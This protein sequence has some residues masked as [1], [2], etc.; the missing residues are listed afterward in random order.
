MEKEIDPV[1][2]KAEALRF[3]A[4]ATAKKKTRRRK[5]QYVTPKAQDSADNQAQAE[6]PAQDPAHNQAQAEIEPN[7]KRK[8]SFVE[9]VDLYK[10]VHLQIACF[11]LSF[12]ILF[13]FLLPQ[14]VLVFHLRL[15]IRH[16]ITTILKPPRTQGC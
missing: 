4:K 8:V 9:K 1:L 3:K 2:A 13:L 7:R 16:R 6:I 5:Q 10:E 14:S 15:F 12:I 11:L